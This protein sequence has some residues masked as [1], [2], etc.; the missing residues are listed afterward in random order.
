VTSQ[1]IVSLLLA[2]TVILAASR[3]LGAAAEK[4]GQPAVIGEILGG[5]L[6]GPTV[7]HGAVGHALF[8]AGIG[9]ALGALASV[10]V[11]MFMFVVGMEVSI[12]RSSRQGTA[13]GVGLAATIVPFL[14]GAALALHLGAGLTGDRRTA[15][16]LFFGSA[17]AVTAFPVLARILFDQ[18]L[19]RTQLGT[20]AMGS[21]AIC[22]V[23]S[24]SL[25]AVATA[26]ARTGGTSP[27][28][29]LL[30][31]P[32][33]MVVVFVV[34]PLL[35]RLLPRISR[36]EV[37]LAVALIGTLLCGAVTERLGLHFIFGAFLFGLVM[38]RDDGTATVRVEVLDRVG[39]LAVVLLLPI[40]FFT[41]GMKVDLSGLTGESVFDLALIIAVAIAAKTVP[42][43]VAARLSRVD[44]RR[45]VALAVLM[46]TRG[47][48]ELIILTVGLDLGILSPS[49]YSLMVVMALVTTAL[50]GPLLR[51]IR[52]ERRA[53]ADEPAT[54]RAASGDPA[55]DVAR[56][57]PVRGG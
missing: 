30:V 6:A 29:V 50:T 36:G 51:L 37:M 54:S 10:G 18:R 40:Y 16:E 25:L 2:L 5:I 53:T 19:M 47:L 42:A 32:F 38:P 4:L 48:T 41:A 24:W 34:K 56:P 12:G 3:L 1:Q 33:A 20:W 15:F 45:S 26:Y 11:A 31:V 22:D 13:V 8:P 39:Q 28:T 35:R 52:P 14:A 43:Y 27:W 17:L 57:D 7:L 23:L 9:T 21:A 55:G 44:P 46:N 49:L